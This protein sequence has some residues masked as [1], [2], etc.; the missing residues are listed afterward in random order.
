MLGKV[1]LRA[2]ARPSDFAASTSDEGVGLSLLMM[3]SPP[4]SWRASR[5]RPAFRRSA[6]KPT[7]VSAATASSTATASRR[8]S[9]ARKS[10]RVWRSASARTE[11]EAMARTVPESA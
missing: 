4:S 2:V 10:R 11:G 6:K 1:A 8:S 3:A 9:P 5:A 7:A